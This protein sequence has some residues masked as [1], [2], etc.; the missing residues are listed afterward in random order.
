MRKIVF[1]DPAKEEMADAAEYYQFHRDRLGSKFLK[2]VEHTIKKSR[3]FLCPEY[4][5]EMV[6]D[7]DS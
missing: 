2:E 7:V 1:L 3:N 5:L 6:F 4:C